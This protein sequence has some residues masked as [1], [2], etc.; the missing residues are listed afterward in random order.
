MKPLT[1]FDAQYAEV[2]S[3]VI[4]KG[5][6][7][8]LNERTNSWVMEA[9]N[10]SFIQR[11]IPLLTLRDIKPRWACVEAVWFLSGKRDVAWLN[12]FGFKAWDSFAD[13]DGYVD[14]ATGWQWRHAFEVDQLVAAIDSLKKDP[15]TRRAILTSWNP[16]QV[17][18]YKNYNVPCLPTWHF[19]RINQKLNLT[20]F[21]RSCDLWF[22]L[23]ADIAGAGI[24]LELIAR[25]LGVLPG[26][27]AIHISNAHLYED[28]YNPA[29]EILERAKIRQGGS[30]PNPRIRSKESLLEPAMKG[31]EWVVHDLFFRIDEWYSKWTDGP[32]RGPKLKVGRAQ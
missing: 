27:V 12:K 9:G 14:S 1:E 17:W 28:A 16:E 11:G 24:I 6:N 30:V 32:I 19:C 26:H 22:G 31:A 20:I 7:P 21:Q 8:Q 15:S 13:S 2:L 23:P 18:M 25:S 4:L 3:R 29:K 5:R 10:I